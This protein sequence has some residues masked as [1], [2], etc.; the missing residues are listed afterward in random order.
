MKYELSIS[1]ETFHTSFS[2]LLCFAVPQQDPLSLRMQRD[3]GKT[4]NLFY[5][6][7]SEI[8]LVVPHQYFLLLTYPDFG[9]VLK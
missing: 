6:Q 1:K 3:I 8:T 5:S 7:L 9:R 2:S 4:C